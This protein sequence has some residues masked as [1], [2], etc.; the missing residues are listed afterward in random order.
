[1]AASRSYSTQQTQPTERPLEKN[2]DVIP[3]MAYFSYATDILGNTQGGNDIPHVQASLLAGLYAGQLAHTFTSHA[4]ITQ[5]CRACQVLI[6]P[7]NLDQEINEARRDLIFFAF[8]TCLQLESDLL[9][10]LDLP[11]SGI[12]RYESYEKVNLP[13]GVSLDV[14]PEIGHADTLNMV[15]YSAQVQLRRTLNRVHTE[16]YK[17]KG[18]RKLPISL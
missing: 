7:A 8:W 12:S 5:A 13:R 18:D 14:L 1:M 10:E 4:W 16:L 6:R 15:Y 3:G 11:A 2:N 9:A 17:D